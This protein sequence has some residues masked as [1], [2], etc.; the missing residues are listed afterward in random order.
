MPV[1]AL[2]D[3][4]SHFV[5]RTNFLVRTYEAPLASDTCT[6]IHAY[7]R[8]KVLIRLHY[9]WAEFCRELVTRSALGSCRTLTG[10]LLVRV[11]GVSAWNDIERVAKEKAGRGYPPWHHA[12]FA[13]G[14]ANRLAVQNFAEISLGLAAISP[15][16][17]L[18]DIRNYIIH[19][20]QRTRLAYN[21]LTYRLGIRGLSPDVL[22][23]SRQSGGA[24]LFETWAADLQI[25]AFNAV[26]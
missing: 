22:L 15:A 25:L 16:D 6:V 10:N 5:S 4:Y 2:Q 12:S 8:T 1:R 18:T 19:P 9:L 24:T 13:L 14:V 3:L 26:R 7:G 23:A 17:D 11:P 20:N 21:K